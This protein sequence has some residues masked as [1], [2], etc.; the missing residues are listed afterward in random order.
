[1]DIEFVKTLYQAFRR[2]NRL[3]I[4]FS[5]R[6]NLIGEALTTTEVLYSRAV[7][8]GMV[9]EIKTERKR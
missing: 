9:A 3:S 6:I 5:G 8:K 1:M 4:Y 2:Y 7:D